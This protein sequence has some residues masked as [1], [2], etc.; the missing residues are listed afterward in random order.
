MADDDFRWGPILVPAYAPS[1]FAATGHGA[2]LAVLAFRAIGLGAD[3]QLAAVV[4]GMLGVGQLVGSLPAGWLV[5]RIGER[6]SLMLAGVADATA[7][8]AAHLVD[9]LVVLGLAIMVSGVTWTTFLMARQ[10]FMID[11]VPPRLRARA[12]SMLGGSHRIGLFLGPLVGA[13]VIHLWGVRAPFLLAAATSLA[14]GA[15]AYGMPDLSADIRGQDSSQVS[16]RSVLSRHRFVLATLGSAI[17]ILGATRAVRTTLLPL[18]AE[19]IGLSAADTSVVI[20]LAAAVD[21]V[22]FYPAGWVMDRFGRVWI[23]VPCV[24]L[25]G[26]GVMLLPLAGGIAALTAIAVLMAVG[27]GIGSGIAMT[28]GADVAP[29]DGRA[30]FLGG[31]RLCGELGGT[32]GPFGV[33]A[34]AA[35]FPLAAACVVSGGLAV[36]G[37]GWV[38]YWVAR[39]DRARLALSRRG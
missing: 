20:G 17:V 26:L 21:M 4:V 24:G 29:V 37:S 9:H 27:N 23:A 32:G 3:A 15:I 14:A 31:W 1:V 10:G 16:V 8:V 5:S 22:L 11:A 13:L 36:L 18:W 6:R 38:G 12:L 34:L 30:Q 25:L 28:L 33:S 7:M 19:H 39:T 35:A 2:V